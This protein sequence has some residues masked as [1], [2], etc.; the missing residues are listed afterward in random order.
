MIG[1]FIVLN[2][3]S[4]EKGDIGVKDKGDPR[5][6]KTHFNVEI[7]FNFV[8]VDFVNSVFRGSE[9][10]VLVSVL[11]KAEFALT[12]IYAGLSVV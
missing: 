5:L 10:Q 11:R 2:S 12:L 9:C 4:S 6:A 7:I 1:N 3:I 8:E